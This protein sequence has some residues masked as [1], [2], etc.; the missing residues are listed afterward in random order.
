MDIL[1]KTDPKTIHLPIFTTEIFHHV[2]KLT[3]CADPYKELKDESNEIALSL[4]PA[5]A[6]K[7][8]SEKGF[9]RFRKVILTS[10]LGN[11]IDFGPGH[12]I[13]SLDD[14]KTEFFE[15]MNQ[16]FEIDD[17]K[18]LYEWLKKVDKIL[19]LGDNAGEIAFDNLLIDELSNSNG[20]MREITYCVKQGPIANDALLVDAK[21][22]G[23]DKRAKLITTG[24][25]YFG[26]EKVSK[27]FW[28]EFNMNGLIISKG[29][30]NFKSLWKK[31]LDKPVAFLLRTKCPGV[32]K[33]LGVDVNKNICL[34]KVP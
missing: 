17:S 7:I 19:I 20:T 18:E 30:S 13:F 34:F 29:Q 32:A 14:L 31:S 28:E 11:L 21:K 4:L 33:I 5:V 23:I 27:E 24:S 15:W 26:V 12:H 2:Y 9:Q 3:G 16:G 10:I 22:V 6:Q 8:H 25:D 1:A